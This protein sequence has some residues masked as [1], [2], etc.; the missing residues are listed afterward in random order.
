MVTC[1]KTAEPIE[2][3]FGLWAWSGSRNHELDR[4]PDPPREGAVLGEASPIVKYRDFLS[5]AVQ[6][7]LNRLICRLGCGLGWA[8]GVQSYSPG[9]A[10]MPSHMGT[11]A[12]PG[13]YDWTVHLRQQCGFISNYFDHLFSLYNILLRAVSLFRPQCIFICIHCS[14]HST[15]SYWWYKWLR[16]SLLWSFAESWLS[17]Q[18]RRQMVRQCFILEFYYLIPLKCV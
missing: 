10:N 7:R 14:L 15:R 18:N 17:H 8:E 9:G 13:E 1:A 16:N 11:L 6:K 2:M 3:S 12:P 5:W 4:G